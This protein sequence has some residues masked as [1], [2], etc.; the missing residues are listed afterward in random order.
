MNGRMPR[1]VV[2]V[3]Y[4]GAKLLDITGPIQAFSWG[5]DLNGAR[6]TDII[7]RPATELES[8][9]FRV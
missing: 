2:I 3:A 6:I 9:P 8:R 4:E 5:S 1:K 7:Q